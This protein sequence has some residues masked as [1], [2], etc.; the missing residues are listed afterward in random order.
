MPFPQ[1]APTLAELFQTEDF[2]AVIPKIIRAGVGPVVAG[3][4]LHWDDLRRRQPP[5]ELTLREWWLGVKFARQ[6]TQREIGLRAVDGSAFT[7]SLPDRAL[8][9][10]HWLDQHA[11]GEIVVSDTIK[12]PGDRSRYLV[13]SLFEEAI[14]SSQLEGASSTRRVA[15]D[16]LRTGRPPR[17]RSERMI[18][19][20][21]TAM[22][23]INGLSQRSLTRDDVLDL[24]RVVTEGTLDNPEAAGRLQQPGE[25]RVHVEDAEG[26]VAHIP[27]PADEL[28]SRLTGMISFA[29]GQPSEGFVHPVVRA[30]LLHL[31]LAYDH[32][33]EDGNGRTARALFYR[34]MLASGYWLFEY[35]TI[36]RLL[37]K[38]PM[39]YARA[40]L[41]TESDEYD[42]TYFILHQLEIC[43]RAIEELHAYLQRKMEET[44][45]TVSL[46]RRADLNH[47]QIALLTNALRHP[48][49]TYTFNSHALS[50]RVVRQSARTDLLD[51]EKR[52][53]LVRHSVGRRHTFQPTADLRAVVTGGG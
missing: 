18:L 37:V 53:Y 21:Y 16:M 29:N 31:W 34:Q 8:E 49:A 9:L 24:H 1:R 17:D 20:N 19:N 36:S 5:S 51:L 32:P 22:S 48:D 11:A 2:G 52:G 12:D 3:K 39:S 35:V 15:K 10:L 50:H 46:L 27:P 33:F 23:M 42:A 47:R 28:E 44:T 40:F 38:A 14:T 25:D 4:Y 43:R 6:Q 45:E 41:H 7:Y 26:R 13:N 30:I